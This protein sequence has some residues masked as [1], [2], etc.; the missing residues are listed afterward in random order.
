[1]NCSHPPLPFPVNPA[2]AIT[3]SCNCATAYFSRRFNGDQLAVCYEEFG[4]GGTSSLLPHGE[5]AGVIRKGIRG[6]QVQLQALGER[7]LRVTALEVM[8]AYRR[9]AGLVGVPEF[10][11]ILEGL[12]GAVAFGTGQAAQ[13]TGRTVAGKTGSVQTGPGLHAAWFAGFAPSRNPEVVVTVLTQGMSGA[14]AAAPMAGDLL[15]RYFANGR[16]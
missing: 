8:E 6:E 3:Y 7:G 5:A 13:V 15:R 4:L 2:R 1:M 11:P 14:E 12:E 9:L 16:P 10:A